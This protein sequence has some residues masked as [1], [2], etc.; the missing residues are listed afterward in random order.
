MGIPFN[1]QAYRTTLSPDEAIAGISKLLN[2]ESKV[3]FI[4][5]RTCYGSVNG[6][7]FKIMAQKSTFPF[8]VSQIKGTI[9]EGRQT[10][11]D[12]R[13]TFPLFYLITFLPF[14]GIIPWAAFQPGQ[15]SIN[16][17]S[18]EATLSDRILIMLLFLGVP[19]FI[20]YCASVWPLRRLRKKV[21]S[22]LKLQKMRVTL[23]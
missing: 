11:V 23:D 18:R 21:I 13:T 8:F 9:S 12:L 1:R 6:S 17:V 19:I 5:V 7:E 3:W 20:L 14:V 4:P 22:E 15:I 16:G 2:E 10:T